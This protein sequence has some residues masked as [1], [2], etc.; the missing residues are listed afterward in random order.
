MAPLSSA[1][2][3]V[4]CTVGVPV[5]PRPQQYSTVHGRPPRNS[6]STMV[7]ARFSS[8]VGFPAVYICLREPKESVP[9]PLRLTTLA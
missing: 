9:H 3:S 1:H 8:D 4:Y 2:H 6:Y 7:A 5:C